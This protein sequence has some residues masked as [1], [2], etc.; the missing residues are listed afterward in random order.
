MFVYAGAIEKRA[1]QA[2]ATTTTT[3]TRTN[4]RTLWLVSQ[5]VVVVRRSFVRLFWGALINWVISDSDSKERAMNMKF[6]FLLSPL[7]LI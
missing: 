4:H 5:E 3:T 1:R 6:K 2:L 7:D